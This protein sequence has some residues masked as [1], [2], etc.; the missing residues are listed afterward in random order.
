MVFHTSIISHYEKRNRSQG[1]AK[2]DFMKKKMA[3]KQARKNKKNGE[4]Y[5]DKMEARVAQVGAMRKS[6]KKA[7]KGVY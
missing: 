4:A 3:R 6:R 2:K 7:R 1:E 5:A